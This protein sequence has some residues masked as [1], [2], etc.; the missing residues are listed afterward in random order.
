LQQQLNACQLPPSHRHWTE[1]DALPWFKKEFEECF[2]GDGGNPRLSLEN[3]LLACTL[4]PPHLQGLAGI[5]PTFSTACKGILFG[6]THVHLTP[7]APNRKHHPQRAAQGRQRAHGRP[8][9]VQ[10]GDVHRRSAGHPTE[11]EQGADSFH[12]PTLHTQ[13]P[14]DTTL[15]AKSDP[16]SAT[17]LT[18]AVSRR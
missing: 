18:H 3:I 2:N 13:H 4:H 6:F 16:S 9:C 14:T 11:G 12:V 5:P 7:C 1:T 15:P 17:F 10:A 8:D